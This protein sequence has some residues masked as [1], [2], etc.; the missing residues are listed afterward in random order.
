MKS[1]RSLWTFVAGINWNLLV[2]ILGL[3]AMAVGCYQ[4][5]KPAAYICAGLILMTISVFGRG[6]VK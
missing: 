3:S 5:Y 4:I 1:N 6:K 2:F